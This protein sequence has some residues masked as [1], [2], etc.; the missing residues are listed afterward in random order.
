MSSINGVGG[1]G[2]NFQANLNANKKENNKKNNFVAKVLVVSGVSDVLVTGATLG[3]KALTRAKESPTADFKNL[4][5]G[6]K[7]K[8]V[9]GQIV[10]MFK[11]AKAAGKL[12]KI[13]GQAAIGFIG[14]AGVAM[15]LQALFNKKQK[16]D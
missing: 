14:V 2:P 5:I 1:Y 15:T 7:I 6:E 13:A 10:E 9:G 12:P 4:K 8:A 3:S 16:Q 11:E